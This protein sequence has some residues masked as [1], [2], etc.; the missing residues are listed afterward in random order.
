MAGIETRLLCILIKKIKKR[1]PNPNIVKLA[2]E[3]E[4]ST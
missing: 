1:N 4:K 3:G 2:E